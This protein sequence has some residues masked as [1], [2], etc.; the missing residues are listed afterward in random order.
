MTLSELE[1]RVAA[2]GVLISR[3]QLMRHCEAQTFDAKRLPA[4][5]NVEQWF[6][7]PASVDKGIAD[8][9]TLQELRARRDG[10]RPDMSGHDG[11]ENPQHNREDM[12][13]HDATRPVMTDHVTPKIASNSKSDTSGHDGLRPAMS[14]QN[15][16]EGGTRVTDTSRHGVPELDIFEHPYVIKL[17]AKI[18]KLEERLEQT[19]TLHR[20]ELM[21][22]Q[23]ASLVAISKNF[24]EFVLQRLGLGSGSPVQAEIIKPEEEQHAP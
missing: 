2:A 11:V 8:I 20:T 7:A 17:E 16:H 1:E 15:K 12:S 4:V 9:K 18:E 6:I 3:R 14:D 13:G 22:L 19:H 23:E 21:K 24:G 5:N 10:T